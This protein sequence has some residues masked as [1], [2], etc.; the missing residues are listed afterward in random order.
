M[1]NGPRDQ[2]IRDPIDRAAQQ[3]MTD[4]KETIQTNS[5]HSPPSPSKDS[6]V[7]KT[8]TD[9]SKTDDNPHGFP[10]RRWHK[11]ELLKILGNFVCDDCLDFNSPIHTHTHT[12]DLC[13]RSVRH[14]KNCRPPCICRV[15]GGKDTNH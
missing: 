15:G 6:D 5:K 10:W 4:Q 7:K 9:E 11:D 8:Q 14:R 12:D 2:V 3:V 1:F 13:R